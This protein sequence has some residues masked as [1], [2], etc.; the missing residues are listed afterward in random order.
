MPM[1]NSNS[2]FLPDEPPPR[3]KRSRLGRFV[4]WSLIL[5]FAAIV[6]LDGVAGWCHSK[7]V[8]RLRA[9]CQ[10]HPNGPLPTPDEI[11]RNMAGWPLGNVPPTICSVG[12][13]WSCRNVFE[14]YR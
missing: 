10:A 2:I 13:S 14:E 7:S 1:S 4:T 11:R 9:Y 3:K 5:I 12:D 6:G 8:E